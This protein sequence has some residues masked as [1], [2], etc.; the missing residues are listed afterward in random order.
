MTSIAAPSGALNARSETAS[1]V[2]S[3]D[4]VWHAYAVVFGAVC[5]MVGGYW[6]ISWHMTVGRDTF[7]TPAHLLIQSGGLIAGLS[8]GFV[9]LKSTIAPSERDIAT[10]VRVW[11]FRGPLGAWLCI[12]GCFAMVAS[13]P[14]DNWWH[15]AYGLDVKIVSPPHTV[16]ALGVYAIVNGAL[17]LT[18]AQQNRSE[19]RDRDLFAILY[20]VA[21]GMLVMTFGTFLTEYGLRFLQHGALFYRMSAIFFPFAL[22]AIARASTVKWPATTAAG[23][24]MG[25]MLALMW[26]IQLV[27]ATPKLGPIYRPITHMVA[28]AW[29]LWLIVPAY[30]IDWVRHRIAGKVPMPVEAIALGVVFSA[31]FFVVQWLWSWFMVRGSWSRN[32]FFNSDNFVY[33]ASPSYVART[34][35]FVPDGSSFG[36]AALMT[37]AIASVSSLVGLAWGSWMA[38]V[39]R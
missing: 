37:L 31:P 22:I 12:W 14:F 20:V 5:V 30:G 32:W 27:P 21:G 1:K 38:R 10:G 34:H 28:M 6:D 16:L 3:A 25:L 19:G 2:R 11:G 23:V 8:A 39:R 7:W 29:P 4:R 17:M 9:V 33:W 15:D 13:A 24:Y 18:L 26:I 36:R 35:V